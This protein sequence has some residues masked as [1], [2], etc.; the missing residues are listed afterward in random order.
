MIKKKFEDLDFNEVVDALA[1]DAILALIRG[2]NWRTIIW[3][4]CQ[5]MSI[6]SAVQEAKKRKKK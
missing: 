6:W 1:G 4:V 3:T 2:S 5:S